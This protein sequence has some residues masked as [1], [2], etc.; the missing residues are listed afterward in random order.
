M[1]PRIKQ[2]ARRAYPTFWTRSKGFSSFRYQGAHLVQFEPAAEKAVAKAFQACLKKAEKKIQLAG[3]QVAV[4]TEKKTDDDPWTCFVAQ[5]KP[6]LLICATDQ[7][8]LEVILSRASG[9]AGKRALPDD[10]P[11]WKQVD[12]KAAVWA[13][14]HYRKETA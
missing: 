8:Y 6:S 7:A 13:I 3:Q 12:T 14:R 11:E 2:P 4:F 1:R 5:P 10:L 9:K